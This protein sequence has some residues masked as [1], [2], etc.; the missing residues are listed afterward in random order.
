[1]EKVK[2][3]KAIYV[4]LMMTVGIALII[5]G[6]FN[7][8]SFVVKKVTLKVYPVNTYEFP[9]QPISAAPVADKVTP[10]ADLTDAQK[11][12]N[13]DFRQS[14]QAQDLTNAIVFLIVGSFLFALHKKMSEGL[15]K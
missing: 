15:D 14:K 5:T 4:Y 2:L 9:N 11:K 6:I 12:G 10:T 1:M 8:T 3:I 13:E 7:T